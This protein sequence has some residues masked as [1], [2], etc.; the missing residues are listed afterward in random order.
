[1]QNQHKKTFNIIHI[2]DTHI[3]SK[4]SDET[5]NI[6]EAVVDDIKN[7]LSEAELKS[8]IICFTGDLIQRGDYGY[9]SE[10]QYDLAIYKFIYYLY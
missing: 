10:K 1:M 2:S 3:S 7:Q 9:L 4:L 6:V 5:N 8:T